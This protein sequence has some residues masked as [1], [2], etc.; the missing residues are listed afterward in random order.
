MHYNVCVS[1]QMNAWMH[2]CGD[3]D[4]CMGYTV[5]WVNV[6]MGVRYGIIEYVW[7]GSKSDEVKPG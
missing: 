1:V 6:Y 3:E 7:Y 2:E 5:E 4:E